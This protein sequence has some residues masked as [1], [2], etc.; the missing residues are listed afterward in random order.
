MET[1][2]HVLNNYIHPQ[3]AAPPIGLMRPHRPASARVR[4]PCPFHVAA[5]AGT[6]T[7]PDR[8]W[9]VAWWSVLV[10]PWQGVHR[11]VLSSRAFPRHRPD[12]GEPFELGQVL[13]KLYSMTRHTERRHPGAITREW[14]AAIPP[15]PLG[16]H[17][18]SRH[19][20]RFHLGCPQCPANGTPVD[21]NQPLAPT[22]T[23]AC[24]RCRITFPVR[25]VWDEPDFSRLA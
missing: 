3:L 19:P 15:W 21:R 6:G 10:R 7:D 11:A 2:P 8:F 25:L 14:I 16:Y 5:Y 4:S 23:I 24:A 18:P 17:Q 1:R 22:S 9:T 12:T 13:A 20:P